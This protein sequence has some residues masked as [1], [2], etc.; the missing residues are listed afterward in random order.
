MS[1]LLTGSSLYRASRCPTSMVLPHVYE[2][3]EESTRG[4]HVHAY[5]ADIANG[6]PRDEALAKVIAVDRR[7]CENIDLEI[8]PDV[9]RSEVSM[10][11]DPNTDAAEL[12][13]KPYPTS[14][15]CGTADLVSAPT[16]HHPMVK[17]WKT[18]SGDVNIQAA[19]EQLAFYALCVARILDVKEVHGEVVV[20]REKGVDAVHTFR[21]GE[22]SHTETASRVR[23][24]LAAMAASG[25]DVTTGQHCQYC[26]ALLACPVT[27]LAASSMGSVQ[28]G[29]AYA[30]WKRLEKAGEALREKVG[31]LADAGH[32][33]PTGDGRVIKR[34][35][36]Q[37]RITTEE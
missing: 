27:R 8:I 34:M 15:V 22:H 30:A 9:A 12:I 26:P 20:I 25:K 6:T 14:G 5:L 18:T 1:H 2:S 7:W 35:G 36:K 24:T 28:P 13:D 11:W 33:L 10:C 19:Y 16:G 32:E 17:D 23:R 29:V 3:S 31:Q 4:D 37:L 21:F